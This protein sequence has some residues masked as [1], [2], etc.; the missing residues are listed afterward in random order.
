MHYALVILAITIK[1]KCLGTDGYLWWWSGELVSV[2][3]VAGWC[4]AH[5]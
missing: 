3:D 5:V 1:W 4:V 2:L